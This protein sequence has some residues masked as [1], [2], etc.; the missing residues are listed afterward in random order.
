M[1]NGEL[2]NEILLIRTGWADDSAVL[3]T[4][5]QST[6]ILAA[7]FDKRIVSTDTWVV[8]FVWL[9]S[10]RV[11]MNN[12]SSPL[13]AAK[14]GDIDK[15]VPHVHDAGIGRSHRSS[16]LLAL[17]PNARGCFKRHQLT[18]SSQIPLHQITDVAEKVMFPAQSTS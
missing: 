1:L 2:L 6:W 18:C 9:I 4:P 7:L 16:E 13:V 15:L 11:L 8:N 14:A 12:F 5:P 17:L 3:K 10:F